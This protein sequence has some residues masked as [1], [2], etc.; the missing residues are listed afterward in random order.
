MKSICILVHSPVSIS[1]N[2]SWT[3]NTLWNTFGW[4]KKLYISTTFL[5]CIRFTNSL[6]E[7]N[8]LRNSLSP[9]RVMVSDVVNHAWIRLQHPTKI[10]YLYTVLVDVHR[11][12][13]QSTSHYGRRWQTLI[14]MEIAI[15][16]DEYFIFSVQF[17]SA[18][19]FFLSNWFFLFDAL[20]N[21]AKLNRFI[22][23]YN[24]VKLKCFWFEYDKNW[25]NSQLFS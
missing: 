11:I 20:V 3:L 4:K 19:E 6:Q 25:I 23:L 24:V 16:D 9:L 18:L 13:V 2:F 22:A 12:Q 21:L 7:E 14:P 1:M 17:V 8:I 10:G 5:V 15:H